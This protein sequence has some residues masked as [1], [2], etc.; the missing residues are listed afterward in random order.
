MSN[1]PAG[2]YLLISLHGLLG[3]GAVIGGGALTLNPSGGWLGMSEDVM[4]IEL[5]PDY[6]IPG[7]ILLAV[8]GIAPLILVDALLRKWNWKWGE[9]LNAIKSMHWSWTFSL[10]IAFALLIWI[11]V[12]IYII[13]GSSVVHLLYT[14]LGLAIQIVSL[15]PSVWRFYEAAK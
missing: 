8:L 2:C 11:S 7:I 3:L 5:F 14:G 1:R 12:Q 13:G 15:L 6:R 9:R 4:K 10:Y